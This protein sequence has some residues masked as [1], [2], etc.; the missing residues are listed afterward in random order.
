MYVTD[1]T[2]FFDKAVDSVTR[3]QCSKS[4]SK[5][6]RLNYSAN[7]SGVRIVGDLFTGACIVN[8]F[9]VNLDC[10]LHAEKFALLEDIFVGNQVLFCSSS[11]ICKPMVYQCGK[12]RCWKAMTMWKRRLKKLARNNI[13][14]NVVSTVH[15]WLEKLV[16][17]VV[18]R[19]CGG[20]PQ[21]SSWFSLISSICFVLLFTALIQKMYNDSRCVTSTPCPDLHI[22]MGTGISSTWL[23]WRNHF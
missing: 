2:I 14:Y 18:Y 21:Y 17:E 11:C 13:P 9:K 6:S 19:F 12:K 22:T 10:H 20:L 16:A 7:F 8:Q 1:Y 15:P 4:K 3:G 23:S 5:Y